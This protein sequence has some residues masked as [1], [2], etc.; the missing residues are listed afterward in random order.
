[1][2]W[3]K[4]IAAGILA[5]SFCFLFVGSAPAQ[6]TNL[7]DGEAC[8]GRSD[9]TVFGRY[10]AVCHSISGKWNR[11]FKAPLGGLFDRKQLVTGQPVNEETVRALL[12]KGSP[13]LMPGFQHT[14]T[15]AQINEL[16]QFLKA[17]RCPEQASGSQQGR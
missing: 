16:V 4:T 14:L 15:P 13:S 3:R 10:C 2:D 5:S 7:C 12:E 11:I 17:A 1:M 8:F 6:Q 9:K